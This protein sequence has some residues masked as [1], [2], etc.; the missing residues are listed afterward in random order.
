MHVI[1]VPSSVSFGDAAQSF[2]PAS[3]RASVN[4]AEQ[5]RQETLRRY[6]REHWPAMTL[7]EY[8][9]GQPDH[10]DSYCR[11]IERQTPHIGSIRG[12]S[13]RKLIIYKR[14]NQPGWH[15]P[16]AYADEQQAWEA[17]RG[18]FVEAMSLADEG[19]WHEIEGIEPLLSGSALVVKTLWMYFPD[20]L[21]PIT[22]RDDL[23]HFLTV[24][25]VDTPDGGAVQ[26]NRALLARLRA[27]PELKDVPTKGLERL[28]YGR[29]S[30]HEGRLIKIAPGENG[31]FWD[32]C[33]EGGYI[34]VGWDEVGDLTLFDSEDDYLDAFRAAFDYST[35]SKQTE[36]AKELWVL[37][38]LG[39]GDRIVANRGTSEV[40]GV[41]IVVAP[42]YVWD[43]SRSEFKHTVRVDWDTTYAKEIPAQPRWGLKTVLVLTGK[44][45]ALVLGD[46][47]DALYDDQIAS[48]RLGAEP[49]FTEI[50]EVLERRGQAVLYG[51]PGTGKTWTARRFATWWLARQNA[52][53]GT[54]QEQ[55]TTPAPS[56]PTWWWVTTS[57][58]GE[59][60]WQELFDNG[61]ETFDR[62]RSLSNYER[63]AAG[64]FVIGYTS[65]PVK[66]IQV[67]A[68]VERLEELDDG[69]TF[70]LAPLSWVGDGPTWDELKLDQELANSQPVRNRA[71]GTL[72]ALTPPEAEHLL[73]LITYRDP[74][75]LEVISAATGEPADLPD[76]NSGV[77][78]APEWITFHPSYSY[79][80][81]VEGFRPTTAVS[82]ARLRLEPGVFKT[83]CERAE[84]NPARTFLLV[85]DEINR[86]NIAKVFGELITLLEKDKRGAIKARL[87]YSKELFSI[88]ANVYVLGTMNTA[89][90]SIKLLDTALRR[91][92]GFVE[93]MP[94]PELLAGATVEGV[95]IDRLLV[96]LNRRI[97][98]IAGREKQIGHSFFLRDEQPLTDA[99]EFAKVFR[100]EI[101][102]LLQ[103][104]TY[105][106]YEA[107]TEYLGEKIVDREALALNQD[108]LADPTLLLEAL[109]DHLLGASD[110]DE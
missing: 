56:P 92:F 26:L 74:A 81:F 15:F 109:E 42:G 55:P 45:R 97:A 71:Q 62:G 24:V 68:R 17:V 98:Q 88:P 83:L 82:G 13:A 2:D 21:L 33:L 94:D 8:A 41:G 66:R 31:R 84:A 12:G 105:D 36:K 5:E 51:P 87:P 75:T 89:D 27:I 16:P 93:V 20:Q 72:F 77:V 14:A 95:Q 9:Q 30:P 65:S 63:I 6:P 49:L 103:E 48:E 101:V 100:S 61:E 3:V 35:R 85:I 69:P 18:G 91:R 23:R 19:R 37:S 57:P 58:L 1:P 34:C 32:E 47:A 53:L 78:D 102:P 10:P 104:Y 4:D 28:L 39:V 38:E 67:L 44:S 80:D 70:V 22:S 46:G 79:E 90:R 7:E 50:A 110:A 29:F 54:P 59:W 52:D 11:W 108:V 25:G 40:L 99:S 107:L 73:S 60:E 86:A 64:D 106:D 96:E 43:E 76:R